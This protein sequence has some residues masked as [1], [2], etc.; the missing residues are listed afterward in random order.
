M[1]LRTDLNLIFVN[2][3]MF[4]FVDRFSKVYHIAIIFKQIVNNWGVN[5]VTR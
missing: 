4:I 1:F 5:K 2:F 3:L